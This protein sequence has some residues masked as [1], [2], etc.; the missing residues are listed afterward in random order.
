[1]NYNIFK[2][3]LQEYYKNKNYVYKRLSTTSHTN[4]VKIVDKNNSYIAKF[5]YDYSKD[6]GFEDMI[7]PKIAFQNEISIYSKLPENWGIKLKDHFDVYIEIN[8]VIKHY[9]VIITN[10][11]EN[12]KWN[13]VYDKLDHE[14]IST[15]LKEQIEW[16]HNN[17]ILH[18][19]LELK[20][21]LISCDRKKVVIIDFEKSL[22]NIENKDILKEDYKKLKMIFEERNFSKISQYF[23]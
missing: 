22:M 3:I 5:I 16:L 15:Q 6:E 1:M 10:E 8:G 18:N 21:I 2:Y 4:V 23:L 19:D 17:K 9:Y 14:S 20:N 13:E 12:C 11:F 7:N